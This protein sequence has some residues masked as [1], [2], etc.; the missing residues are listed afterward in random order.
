M[1]LN[2]IPSEC[3]QIVYTLLYK[4]K[5]ILIC[6][7]AILSGLVHVLYSTEIAKSKII[8]VALSKK[9]IYDLTLCFV[10]H[11]RWQ[12]PNNNRTK[13]LLTSA[14]QNAIFDVS[15]SQ[16]CVKL[17]ILRT[18]QN[19]WKSLTQIGDLWIRTGFNCCFLCT[20]HATEQPKL[21]WHPQII[22]VRRTKKCLR[23]CPR[24]SRPMPTPY[25][26]VLKMFILSLFPLAHVLR[27]CQVSWFVL[28]GKRSSVLSHF[29]WTCSLVRGD[30]IFSGGGRGRR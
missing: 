15:A 2:L 12:C 29:C 11:L 4:I 14:M 1:I 21:S 16:G 9:L 26:A 3:V 28:A 23:A 7:T 19:L 30:W 25:F 22:H 17:I 8:I 24:H 5:W 10:I 20:F 13:N 6:T 27:L 18:N